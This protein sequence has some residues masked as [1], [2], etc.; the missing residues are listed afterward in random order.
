M[1]NC[2]C[3]QKKRKEREKK[4]ITDPFYRLHVEYSNALEKDIFHYY[5]LR[6]VICQF[7]MPSAFKP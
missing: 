2:R 4:Y 1:N 3:G 6:L 7:Q 5:S